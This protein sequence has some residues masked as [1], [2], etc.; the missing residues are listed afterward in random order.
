M[1]CASAQWCTN[2]GGKHDWQI[3]DSNY[4]PTKKYR[5]AREGCGFFKKCWRKCKDADTTCSGCHVI[6]H[7]RW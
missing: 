7:K 2:G 5:C 4:T 3:W 1:A 6:A